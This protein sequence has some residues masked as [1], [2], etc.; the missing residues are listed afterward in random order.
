VDAD[1]D[2]E[3]DGTLTSK[4]LAELIV[5]ALLQA[6]IVREEDVARSIAIATEEIEVRKAGGDY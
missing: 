2:L 6:R 5:D 3:P 1:D 4:G